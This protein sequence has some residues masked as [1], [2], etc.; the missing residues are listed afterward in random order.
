MAKNSLKESLKKLKSII[1]W[2]DQQEE[3][4]VEAG[5]ERV[6]EGAQLIRESRAEL[7]NL[8]NEFEKVKKELGDGADGGKSEKLL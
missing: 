5:L 2:F 3:V 4:D 8:E 7:K 6:K 1:A